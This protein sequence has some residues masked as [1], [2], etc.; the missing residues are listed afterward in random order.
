M[1]E[2]LG[3]YFDCLNDNIRKAW[4]IEELHMRKNYHVSTLSEDLITHCKEKHHH[5]KTIKDTPNYVITWNYRYASLFQFTPVDMRDTEAEK[6]QSEYV[7]KCLNVAYISDSF[8]LED[9]S[10]QQDKNQLV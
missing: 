3:N 8:Y 9:K 2:N 5:H 4:L 6:K 7:L 1:D 10:V